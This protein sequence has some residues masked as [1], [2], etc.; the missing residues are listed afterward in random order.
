MSGDPIPEKSRELFA[1]Q[2]DSFGPTVTSAYGGALPADRMPQYLTYT[3]ALALMRAHVA[4]RQ[5]AMY[6]TSAPVASPNSDALPA[7]ESVRATYTDFFTMFDVPFEYGAPWSAADDAARAPV[8]VLSR[9]L[10]ERLFGGANSVG[11]AVMLN[12]EEFRIVGVIQEWDPVPRFY[13]LGSEGA[14]TFA[15]FSAEQLFVPF[16]TAI[17]LDLPLFDVRCPTKFPQGS[18]DAVLHSECIFFQMW[19]E[20]P[21]STSV[22]TYRT[23]LANY[24]AQQRRLGRFHWAPRIALRD[25]PQWL[26]YHHVVSSDV[27]VLVLVSFAFLLVCLLNG[28]GLMLAKFMSRHPQVSVRRAL[29]ADRRAIFTQ[30]LVEIG[31]IGLVAG[32][33]GIALSM[34]GLLIAHGMFIRSAGN[35]PA[36]AVLTHLN[37]GDVA[38]A[39]VLSVATTLLAGLYPTWRATRVQPA[40]Q[41]KV[42]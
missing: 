19:V 27:S 9:K 20:L 4:E 18:E 32:V 25:V 1:P 33:V 2:I 6:V 34:V 14:S 17:A 15:F 12:S 30:C 3:D 28:G 24:E 21:N 39:V 11:R 37:G 16:T 22:R 13:D 38:I 5:A 29:G 35:S 7:L 10:N 26:A 31:M 40:W 41:L 42:Q 8:I 23:F 36:Q